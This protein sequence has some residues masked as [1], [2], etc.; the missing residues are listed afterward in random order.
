MKQIITL[1]IASMLMASVSVA[2]AA[3]VKSQ[4]LKAKE[5]KVDSVVN[6]SGSWNDADTVSISSSTP[7]SFT[8]NPQMQGTSMGEIKEAVDSAV[9]AGYIFVLIIIGLPVLG[10]LVIAYLSYRSK[11][12]RYKL[13]QNAME[14]GVSLPN[15][16][17]NNMSVSVND[18][19]LWR[20]GIKKLFVGIGL[21]VLG[22]VMGIDP[23]EAIGYFVAIFGAGQMFIAYS[24][25][26]DLLHF[27]F[28]KHKGKMHDDDFFKDN[29]DNDTL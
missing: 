13:M 27:G 19:M 18:E 24:S 8:I 17:N 4:E 10:C 5:A 25:A 7:H 2:M 26:N 22:L 21:I 6:S 14:K 12:N 29:I 11:N 20:R 9:Q 3:T 23:L 16:D 15:P 28:R 1:L